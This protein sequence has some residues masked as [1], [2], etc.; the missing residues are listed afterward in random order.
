M[1]LHDFS[2][3]FPSS[4]HLNRNA[5][6]DAKFRNKMRIKLDFRNHSQWYTPSLIQPL[7]S[8][9]II[10]AEQYY[11][12]SSANFSFVNRAII[13]WNHHEACRARH[14]VRVLITSFHPVS[15][16]SS[17][18]WL[19]YHYYCIS[20]LA[21]DLLDYL[22]LKAK[23]LTKATPTPMKKRIAPQTYTEPTLCFSM[24]LKR[25]KELASTPSCVHI[26]KN[27]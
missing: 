11:L 2:T 3:K 6:S 13:A 14:I 16:P 17:P 10:Q 7:E 23:N 9:A 8:E 25:E 1:P 24:F 5:C 15:I 4:K 22:N 26:T 20:L 12:W 19:Q 18:H 27:C 21:S